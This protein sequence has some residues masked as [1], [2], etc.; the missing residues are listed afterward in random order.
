[1]QEDSERASEADCDHQPA[2]AGPHSCI[3]PSRT[4]YFM[5]GVSRSNGAAPKR[6]AAVNL[7]PAVPVA[8]VH[9]RGGA[10]RDCSRCTSVGAAAA[11][12]EDESAC[13]PAVH[14]SHD[15][16]AVLNC[17]N[18]GRAAAQQHR[19]RQREEWRERPLIS[20]PGQVR[21]AGPGSLTPLF[22]SISIAIADSGGT[23]RRRLVRRTSRQLLAPAPHRRTACAPCQL[24]ASESAAASDAANGG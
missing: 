18:C 11:H 14:P 3:S 9:A 16:R 6:P 20:A 10:C 4:V 17:Q 7:T 12:S 21:G 5:L 13:E 8:R 2:I 15:S 24:L 19:Q 23:K 1:M 22:L